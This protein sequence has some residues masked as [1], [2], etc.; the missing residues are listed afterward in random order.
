MTSSFPFTV[1][2]SQLTIMENSELLMVNGT[3]GAAC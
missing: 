1:N 2:R 3:G